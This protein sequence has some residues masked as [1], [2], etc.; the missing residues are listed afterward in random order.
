M[1]INLLILTFLFYLKVNAQQLNIPKDSIFYKYEIVIND[2]CRFKIR[3]PDEIETIDSLI[4][5]NY[6]INSETRYTFYLK[7]KDKQN[8][9]LSF[10]SVSDKNGDICLQD[11]KIKILILKLA[12]K[13][14]IE[15]IDCASYPLTFM[16]PFNFNPEN[17][18]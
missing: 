12:E 10:L 18:D 1:K 11:K 3:I 4:C 16:I 9:N 2:D 14:K 15:E 7:I 17:K 5:S 13:I 8:F 6:S